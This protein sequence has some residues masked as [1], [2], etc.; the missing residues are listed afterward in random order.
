[1]IICDFCL[2]VCPSIYKKC[3]NL[4]FEKY[5]FVIFLYAICPRSSYPFYMVTY[6]MIWVTTSCADN[7]LSFNNEVF[8][9]ILVHF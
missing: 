6:Y 7:K 1:M 2:T 4:T 8:F 3:L 5:F 9:T